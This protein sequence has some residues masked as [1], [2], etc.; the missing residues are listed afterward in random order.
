MLAVFIS[1]IGCVI[2]FSD[3][4]F[5]LGPRLGSL[6]LVKYLAK[7]PKLGKTKKRQLKVPVNTTGGKYNIVEI[8]TEFYNF[9]LSDS[10][11]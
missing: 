2:A 3:L 10:M 5:S 9:P 8:N 1:T 4:Q 6:D 11:Q 7:L